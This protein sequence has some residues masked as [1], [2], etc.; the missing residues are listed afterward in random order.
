MSMTTPPPKSDYVKAAMPR[1]ADLL[2]ADGYNSS[3]DFY[4]RGLTLW[5]KYFE[6]NPD[7]VDPR[8]R[9]PRLELSYDHVPEVFRNDA[10]RLVGEAMGFTTVKFP[11]EYPTTE[12]IAAA[13]EEMLDKASVLGLRSALY[14]NELRKEYP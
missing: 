5:L 8:R 3:A 12:Q 7:S 14:V 6:L 4:Y 1:G 2:R 10:R 9:G 11:N 13:Y